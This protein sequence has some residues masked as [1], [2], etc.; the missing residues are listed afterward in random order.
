MK[1]FEQQRTGTLAF[2]AAKGAGMAD[3]RDLA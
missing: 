2:V 3:L 1:K